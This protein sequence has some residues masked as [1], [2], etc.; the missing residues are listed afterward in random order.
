M[1]VVTQMTKDKLIVIYQEVG[2]SPKLQKIQ[3]DITTFKE[4]L[5]RRNRIN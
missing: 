2:K 5:G 3:N 4:I 1:K